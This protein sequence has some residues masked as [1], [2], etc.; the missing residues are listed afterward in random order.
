[1]LCWG[2]GFFVFCFFS[3]FFPL[4]KFS[5]IVI[6]MGWILVNLWHTNLNCSELKVLCKTSPLS[7]VLGVYCWCWCR[8]LFPSPRRRTCR[9][10]DGCGSETCCSSWEASGER[11][12]ACWAFRPGQGPRWGSV[13]IW[14]GGQSVSRRQS[15]ECGIQQGERNSCGGNA[16]ERHIPFLG[17]GRCVLPR[18]ACVC[19]QWILQLLQ[20]FPR[21]L[22]FLFFPFISMTALVIMPEECVADTMI[23]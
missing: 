6:K 11:A 22:H 3:F 18:I 7:F 8:L 4:G 19:C 2:Q 9:E 23:A 14:F 1:M 15:A 10:S 21:L 20:C 16:S 13:G 12:R 17:R 5:S